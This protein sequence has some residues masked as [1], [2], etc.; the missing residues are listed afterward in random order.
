MQSRVRQSREILTLICAIFLTGCS[1][2]P[3]D[4]SQLKKCDSFALENIYFSELQDRFPT[5]V[6]TNLKAQDW[7][8]SS[9]FK[10]DCLY[11]QRPEFNGMDYFETRE[12]PS[13]QRII[14]FT[15]FRVTDTLIGFVAGEEDSRV[16]VVGM[17]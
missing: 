9:Q 8:D 3:T 17:L 10:T 15:P 5:K 12:S 13:G 11:L 1:S 7:V 6:G 2:Q 16:L 4:S 14:L